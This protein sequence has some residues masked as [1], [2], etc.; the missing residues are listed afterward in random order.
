MNLYFCCLLYSRNMY[1][2]NKV[3]DE[4]SCVVITVVDPDFSE[5]VTNPKMGV[6]LPCNIFLKKYMKMRTLRPLDSPLIDA[7]VRSRILKAHSHS[8][9]FPIVT[10]IFL[11]LKMGYN[12]GVGDVVAVT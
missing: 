6:N 10:V 2:Y 12:M 3:S 1:F 9:F 5:E 8:D 4:Y 11:L 7:R